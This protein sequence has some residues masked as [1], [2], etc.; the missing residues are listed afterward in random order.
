MLDFIKTSIS[1]NGLSIVKDISFT[2]KSSKITVLL[3]KNGSGKS[4]L[5]SALGGSTKY[6]GEIS[7]QGQSLSSLFAPER[8]RKIALLPQI[9][10]QTG[11]SV[12]ELCILGRNP[13][14]GTLGFLSAYDR[15]VIDGALKQ[16]RVIELRHRALNTL[17]GGERQRA[18]IAMMLSQQAELL[19][20][21][22]PTTFMDTAARRELLELCLE[23]R[24]CGKTLLL[25]L[26]DLSEAVRI[27]DDII[28]IES[29]KVTFKGSRETCL[30]EGAIEHAFD[31]RRCQDGEDIFFI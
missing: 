10:P 18:F 16:A 19:V 13:H 6:K 8:A 14:I 22:E 3:G 17:S 5:L 12:E 28:I 24:S 31:V 30:A 29:G 1:I 27:A 21:D 2:V 7:L 15:E 25:V 4:T 11:M 9:L 26:H 23:L 20:M